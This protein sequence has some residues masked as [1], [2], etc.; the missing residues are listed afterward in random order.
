MKKPTLTEHQLKGYFKILLD[1]MDARA[2][3][4]ARSRLL[5]ADESILVEFLDTIIKTETDTAALAYAAELIVE[6]NIG[7]KANHIL[8][9][10]QSLDSVLRRHICGLLGNCRDKVALDILIERLQSD[11]SADVRV[12][13]AYALGKI[14][15]RK[16]LPILIWAKDYDLSIDFE[17]V[18]VSQ[19]ANRAID[20]IENQTPVDS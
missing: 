10:V 14:G 7:Q 13:A 15:D 19:Q 4:Q 5:E 2:R 8:L 17:G 11:V 18:V 3:M 9:L 1:S 16:A 12:V 20:E 6:S